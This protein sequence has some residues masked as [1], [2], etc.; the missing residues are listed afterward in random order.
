M[1]LRETVNKLV[2]CQNIKM[3]FPRAFLF[4][5]CANFSDW[6]TYSLPY[7]LVLFFDVP[8]QSL[9]QFAAYPWNCVTKLFCRKLLCQL[10]NSRWIHILNKHHS[11]YSSHCPTCD[12]I[13][14]HIIIPIIITISSS[15][16]LINNENNNDG[17]NDNNVSNKRWK[18]QKHHLHYP[19]IFRRTQTQ[20]LLYSSSRRPSTLAAYT[21]FIL[22]C[23]LF[24]EIRYRIPIFVII[25]W[26]DLFNQAIHRSQLIA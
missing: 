6:V 8:L 20:T 25:V 21:H 26:L 24:R 7:S 23:F 17:D 1:I 15:S 22:R 19:N 11:M 18:Q 12:Q 14:W 10:D 2:Y 9:M 16:S 3:L 4:L 13:M 5:V